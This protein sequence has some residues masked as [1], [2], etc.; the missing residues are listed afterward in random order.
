MRL[1]CQD[2]N[3]ARIWSAFV[4]SVFA[5]ICVCL[6]K[7]ILDRTPEHKKRRK[8]LRGIT[9]RD[10]MDME[11]R[12]SEDMEEGSEELEDEKT[13]NSTIDEGFLVTSS[14]E[15]SIGS[16]GF[17][18]LQ[19][20]IDA[21]SVDQLMMTIV[22]GFSVLVGL[23]WDMAFEAAESLIVAPGAVSGPEVLKFIGVQFT[24]HRVVAKC[25]LCVLLVACVLPAWKAHVVP[26]SRRLWRHH[27]EDI[28]REEQRDCED[29]HAG[30]DLP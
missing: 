12:R 6:I 23:G 5:V 7:K 13:D 16:P 9:H 8:D 3:M 30:W 18:K 14:S 17:T 27:L 28:K 22:R 20:A 19:R 21:D 26:Y 25:M 4:V 29:L 15:L 11:L 1:I 10:L 24:Q 2:K